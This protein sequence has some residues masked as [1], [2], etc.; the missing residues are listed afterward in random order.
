M[1][2]YTFNGVTV[3]GS[4]IQAKISKVRLNP[5]NPRTEDSQ[6]ENSARLCEVY[7][8]IGYDASQPVILVHGPDDTMIGIRGNG[9]I[10]GALLLESTD[11]TRYTEVFGKE[12]KIPAILLDCPT[13][14]EIAVI[15]ADH[16]GVDQRKLSL[17]EQ[18]LSVRLSIVKAFAD[19]TTETRK[20]IGKFHGKSA[21]W[22]QSY[23]YLSELQ[24]IS[25]QPGKDWPCN[26]FDVFVTEALQTDKIGKLR[27]GHAK[28]LRPFWVTGI[29]AEFWTALKNLR[30]YGKVEK[31]ESKPDESDKPTVEQDSAFLVELGDFVAKSQSLKMFIDAV[32]MRS[33]QHLITADNGCLTMESLVKEVHSKSAQE[34][35]E[36]ALV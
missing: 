4:D 25:A 8:E 11:A 5:D 26:P 13:D 2:Y 7:K 6:K 23:Q 36:N 15:M 28:D 27:I 35:A 33:L 3:K 29:D 12:G 17:H 24:D 32:C 30:R 18:Y 19:D 21:S 20:E 1:R 10:G 31:P 16:N 9:R 22:A 14:A 34:T